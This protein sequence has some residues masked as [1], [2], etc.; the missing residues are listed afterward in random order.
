MKEISKAI[1][2]MKSKCPLVHNI[3]NFVVMNVTANA[4]LAVGASPVMAHEKEEFEDMLSIASA[5]V[6][7]IGTLDKNNILAMEAAGIIAKRKN[8]PIVLDPVGAG[9]TKLRT[10]TALNILKIATPKILRANAS[11]VM[12]VAGESVKTKGVDST[13]SGREAIEGAKYIAKTYKCVV[14]VSGETDIITDG[15]KTYSVTGGSNLM[16]LV[17][18]MGCT[19]TAISGAMLSASEPLIAASSAMAI[20]ASAGEMAGKAAKGPGSFLS[21]FLD[22]L[23]F[24]NIEDAALR[25][26]E[27]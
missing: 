5:L 27:E 21:A 10:S 19:A 6:I 7:N 3:T 22:A 23:Y 8:V 25:V 14:S 2:D 11:E 15:Y 24:L 16:P 12:A 1:S 9:A 4:L 13:L 17:T 26:K 20:M 18:G